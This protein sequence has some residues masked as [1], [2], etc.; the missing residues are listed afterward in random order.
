MDYNQGPEHQHRQMC[1]GMDL[2]DRIFG[3][4]VSRHL[5]SSCAEAK[6]RADF[7]QTSAPVEGNLSAGVPVRRSF[8]YDR[9]FLLMKS[10]YGLRYP[11]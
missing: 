9:K 10:R 11:A 8:R 1:L 4:P 6:M 3:R 2:K 7:S 5:R